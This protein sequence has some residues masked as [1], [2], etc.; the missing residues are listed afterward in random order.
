MKSGSQWCGWRRRSSW[1]LI[2][3]WLF[4]VLDP[5][6][7]QSAEAHVSP[8]SVI[9]P[10]NSS[11]Q[12]CVV[13]T[14]TG[15]FAYQWQKN[16]VNLNGQ[17]NSCLDVTN[18]AIGDGGSYRAAVSSPE[19]GLL[20][21]E[22]VLVVGLNLLPGADPFTKGTPIAAVSNSVRG[23]LFGSS[24]E[25]GEPM[26]YGLST[27]NSVWYHWTAPKTGI[28]TFDTRGSA[29]DTVLAVYSGDDL[30]QLKE[31]V[32]DDDGGGF[33]TSRVSWN[34]EAGKAYQVAIDGVTGENGSYVC[35]WALE[36]TSERLPVIN[37]QPTSQ[38]V[39]PGGAALFRVTA[40][41]PDPQ[42]QF[43]WLR[44]GQA[45]PGANSESLS[46]ENVGSEHLGSYQ[47]EVRS[48]SGRSVLSA[49]AVL[50]IGSVPDVQ[51]KDK[52][53]ELPLT[54]NSEGARRSGPQLMGLG[55]SGS[56]SL[57][58]GTVINQRFFNG[59]TL[60]RC[61]P[62]HCGVPGGASRWFQLVAASNGIC[63]L[64][65]VGSDVDTILAVYL[66]NSGICTKLYEPLVDC[67]ND[68]LG[69]CDD[70]LAPNAISNRSSRV[71]FSAIAGTVFRVVIDTVGGVRGT[72]VH[73]NVSYQSGPFPSDHLV[74]LDLGT[75]A[76]LQIR[77]TSVTLKAQ[78][79]SSPSSSP[80]RWQVNGRTI[81]GAL[82]DELSLP[83]LNYSDA[84][85]YTVSV[86]EGNAPIP[87]GAVQLS[88]VSPCGP[89]SLAAAPRS[90]STFP[91]L[92]RASS[93][94]I[95]ESTAA[96]TPTSTWTTLGPIRASVEPIVWNVSTGSSL[97][98]RMLP[99]VP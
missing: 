36:A 15:P 63:T 25:P 5:V 51:S 97:F 78:S 40:T 10:L 29:L 11:V 8:A 60:D 84:G 34:A 23:V 76:L 1:L 6:Q 12:L 94:L 59:S 49:A 22:G 42:L 96:L 47:V 48:S 27:S 19:G 93:P 64:D 98:Y 79:H 73:L 26:H 77:G 82:T 71:S 65:T 74:Q 28:A 44:N 75:N 95:L 81:A 33:H 56:F 45:L 67:N 86:Q 21:E 85:R 99:S 3:L 31:L 66:Q 46:I 89:N 72:N 91:I 39:S 87:L 53:A 69:E 17:T 88:I 35:N 92:G 61:E 83:F 16:G 2:P 7:A 41:H 58:A 50:E 55:A 14:G 43:Q 13:A 68:V 80:Y 38:T 30:G 32:S 18:V 90:Q 57:S 20:S 70:M 37:S 9:A 62:A 52:L 24:R 4:G 54:E